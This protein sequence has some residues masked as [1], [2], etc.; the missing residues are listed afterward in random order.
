MKHNS[1]RFRRTTFYSL[2]KSKVGNILA[3]STDLRINLNIDGASIASHT[4]TS[5]TEV[6]TRRDVCDSGTE[7]TRDI[8]TTIFDPAS[9]FLNFLYLVYL[10]YCCFTPVK[11]Q[12]S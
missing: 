1:F 10:L 6:E 8:E 11:Q 12:F 9:D 3:K 4:H 2:L 5:P 7:G